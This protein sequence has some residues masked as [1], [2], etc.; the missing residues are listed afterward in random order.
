MFKRIKHSPGIRCSML[1]S[2]VERLN[3]C[4]VTRSSTSSSVAGVT[5]VSFVTCLNIP[6]E[7]YLCH[8]NRLG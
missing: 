2:A 6:A 5:D 4:N 3:A 8:A 1:G 7:T